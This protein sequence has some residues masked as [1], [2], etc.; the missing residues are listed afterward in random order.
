MFSKLKFNLTLAAL[1]VVIA[2]CFFVSTIAWTEPTQAPP[3]GNTG[4]P[5]NVGTVSQ[6]KTGDLTVGTSS[7]SGDVTFKVYA[8]GSGNSANIQLQGGTSS[9]AAQIYQASDNAL[10]FWVNG[11]Q[12]MLIN[13]SGYVGIGT[14]SPGK[15]LVVWDDLSSGTTGPVMRI[16]GKGA[17]SSTGRYLEWGLAESDIRGWF[18]EDGSSGFGIFSNN[19]V[20]IYNTATYYTQFNGNGYN[21]WIFKIPSRNIV[22]STDTTGIRHY[23]TV[24]PT[25]NYYD[26]QQTAFEYFAQGWNGTAYQFITVAS[27]SGTVRDMAFMGGN[28]GIGTTAPVAKLQIGD[29]SA[30]SEMRIYGPSTSRYLRI[31]DD[32]DVHI[33]N[34][35]GNLDLQAEGILSLYAGDVKRMH[36]SSTGN[37]GIGTTSPN[38]KLAI[39]GGI[40]VGTSAGYYSGTVA[41]GAI[42][43]GKVGIGM[44]S[45]TV[46]LQVAGQVSISANLFVSGGISNY[47]GYYYTGSSDSTFSNY[48]GSNILE[49]MRIKANTGNVGIGTTAPGANLDVVNSAALGGYQKLAEFTHKSTN[50]G[51]FRIEAGGTDYRGTRLSFVENDSVSASW[52]IS[53]SLSGYGGSQQFTLGTSYTP[54]MTISDAGNV[55]IG[56]TSPN[57]ALDVNGQIISRNGLWLRRDVS[58]AVT[59]T[60]AANSVYTTANLYASDYKFRISATEKVTIDANGNVGIGTTTPA[61]KL[62]VNGT[63]CIAGD[64]KA[65]WSAAA[66]SGGWTDDGTTV[67]LTASTDNISIGT[68]DA[69]SYPLVIQAVENSE[70]SVLIKR[71]S[72]TLGLFSISKAGYLS[73]QARGFIG[74]EQ[75]IYTTQGSLNLGGTDAGAVVYIGNTDTGGIMGKV[76]IGT[77][78]PAARL[79]VIGLG[80]TSAT[81]GLSVKNSDLTSLLYV[82]NDG[83]VG[84]GTTTSGA[85]LNLAGDLMLTNAA[86]RYVYVQPQSC[87]AG[88]TKIKTPNGEK[89]IRDIRIGDKILSYDEVKKEFKES[90]VE[91]IFNREVNSYYILNGKIK[92]TAEH[93]FYTKEG[94]KKVR[95]LKMGDGLFNSNQSWVKVKSKI[96][97]KNKL[98]VY[99]L[100]TSKPNTYF[101]DDVLVHNK[102][103]SS[104]KNLYIFP[105]QKFTGGAAVD[106]NLILGFDGASAIGNVGIGTTPTE[107]LDVVGNLKVNNIGLNGAS[108]NANYLLS[109]YNTTTGLGSDYISNFWDST[110]GQYLQTFF[111]GSGPRI[112]TPNNLE[113]TGGGALTLDTDNYA[114]YL[115][116]GGYYNAKDLYFGG[117]NEFGAGPATEASKF[118]LGEENIYDTYLQR[119]NG[120]LGVNSLAGFQVAQLTAGTGTV[121]ITTNTTCTGTNT[122][123]LNTFKVGDSII[124]TATAETRA[125]SA[126]ASDTVMTIASATNTAGSA[127]T[128]TGGDR[129]AVLGNGNV[130]IG[131]TTPGAK[132]EIN[133]GGGATSGLIIN[134]L[135]TANYGIDLTN[136]GLSGGSDYLLKGV[137]A[138]DFWTAGGEFRASASIQ[139]QGW[140]Q[141]STILYTNSIQSLAS[142]NN[143]VLTPQGAGYTILNGNV[144]I[145]TITPGYKLDVWD[146]G[147]ASA[148]ARINNSN[149]TRVYTGLRLDRQASEKWFVGMDTTD[150]DLLFRRAGTTNDV[151]IATSGAMGIGTTTPTSKLQVVGLPTYANNAAAIAGGLTTGAFYQNG[152]DPS[153]VCVVY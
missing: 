56:T 43:E 58:S 80:T 48:D 105:G 71:S 12:R 109:N 13:S 141:A 113:I 83:N 126:I 94:W 23:R 120:F 45:P 27:G 145:G 54:I 24:T 40:A 44:T 106:G 1:I 107:K 30:N 90:E 118:Y 152:A 50:R 60:N 101:A 129:F 108:A 100:H 8:G 34:V 25:G 68:T 99:N 84:I 138:H 97:I 135:G 66:G 59:F 69:A 31:Y 104:G 2:F 117:Y 42:I 86:D 133:G 5:I 122:Q 91:D 35:L 87:F 62:D 119:R 82:R 153:V 37:V 7:A 70:P 125:I 92:V 110:G 61:G 55:G 81:A 151:V 123:F 79:E 3:A 51:T 52:L 64:C 32:N 98:I 26:P 38:S 103:G 96:E 20:N 142:G 72:D 15:K 89:L 115:Q 74:F 139:S 57:A 14:A 6:T 136:S 128:L 88:E 130:G 78:T 112:Y 134:N 114:I 16:I 75:P 149:A 33:R 85:K 28:V 19:G 93:P 36:I 131:T 76:G 132:L 144:G 9:A 147:T 46:A 150:D 111:T 11:A 17:V 49:R 95:E 146:T 102:A 39:N 137:S 41:D 124:I 73:G 21:N 22:L 4:A 47:N 18:R 63:L 10:N 140:I 116:P 148:M 65:S 77:P 67:R 29:G 53:K 127:Y 143:I 121:T